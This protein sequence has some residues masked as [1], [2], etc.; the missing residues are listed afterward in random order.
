MIEYQLNP[1]HS[2]QTPKD[3]VALIM[4]GQNWK[5][6][7]KRFYLSAEN[8]TAEKIEIKLELRKYLEKDLAPIEVRNSC[9]IFEEAFKGVEG[10]SISHAERYKGNLVGSEFTY[11]EID[12]LHFLPLMKIYAK[13]TGGVFWDLGCGTGKAMM[14]A[15]LCDLNFEKVC[16]VE[17]LDGLYDSALKTITKYL[18]TESGKKRKSNY[19]NLV[20]GDMKLVDWTDA[21]MIYTSSICFPEELIQAL[22]EK[23]K[24]LKKGTII[25]SLKNWKD[26]SVFKVLEYLQVK[27]TW[28]KT[29]VYIMERI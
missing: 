29:G 9:E 21:D 15:S 6:V 5:H 23:G 26:S 20:K 8:L 12:F 18:E 1:G 14:A 27:M 28:G 16:G 13:K 19:F 2:F 17:L 4:E 24:M 7:P 22:T 25:I 11:G 3:S 10:G